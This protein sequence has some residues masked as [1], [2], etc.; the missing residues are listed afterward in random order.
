MAHTRPTLVEKAKGKVPYGLYIRDIAEVRE[1][2]EAFDF[3]C[4][5][6]APMPEEEDFCMSLIGSECSICLQC[7][8]KFARDW[9]VERF[10]ALIDDILSE[11]EKEVRAKRNLSK[12]M[13]KDL[14]R[15]E[16]DSAD[17]I[18]TLLIRGVQVIHHHPAGKIVRSYCVYDEENNRIVVQPMQKYWLTF[19]MPKIYSLHVSDIAEIRTGTKRAVS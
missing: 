1:G 3:R 19:L 4:N 16:I 7:P 9:F 18:R 17:Q 12:L 2:A 6:H 13:L 14:T 15:Q 11:E 10:Q 8:S 5:P